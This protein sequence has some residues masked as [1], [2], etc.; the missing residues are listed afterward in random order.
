MDKSQ[1]HYVNERIHSIKF[2][3]YKILE[4]ASNTICLPGTRD[5]ERDKMQRGTRK[6]SCYEKKIF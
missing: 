3:L 6:L 4:K 2:H 1:S 5:G